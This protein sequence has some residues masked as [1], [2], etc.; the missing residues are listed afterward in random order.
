MGKATVTAA[1]KEAIRKSGL[2]LY[3]LAQQ[4]GVQRDSIQRFMAGRQSLRLD[5]ADRLCTFFNLEVMKRKG[6]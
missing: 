6:K 5:K 1:L 2:S 4:T 3:S